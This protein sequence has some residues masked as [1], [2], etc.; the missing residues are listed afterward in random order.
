[1]KL[2]KKAQLAF[3]SGLASNSKCLKLTYE[4][5]VGVK[6]VGKYTALQLANGLYKF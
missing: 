4:I 2:S 3:E 5:S 1:M 6:C